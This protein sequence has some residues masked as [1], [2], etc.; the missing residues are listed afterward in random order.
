MA[1]NKDLRG[2]NKFPWWGWV[3]LLFVLVFW[4]LNW[5][6]EGLRTHIG[7]FPLWL[8][9]CLSIDALTYMRKG[10]SLISRNLLAYFSLFIVSAPAWWLFEL[11]NEKAQYWH[12]THR[13]EFT[14][15][16]YFLYASMSFSTVI[17]A[18]FGTSEWMGSFRWIQNMASGPRIGNSRS[19]R[20]IMLTLGLLMFA[21]LFIYPQYSAAFI[22]MSLYLIL[23]PLNNILGHRTLIQHTGRG[24]W[25]EV[26]ALWVASLI[27]GFFWELW[28]IYSSPKW[29]YTVPYVDFW[30]VFEMPLL[31][32]L[33]YLPFALEL[34]ALYHLLIGF[35]AK[36]KWQSYLQILPEVQQN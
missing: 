22:W 17:P 11:L 7:F 36:S 1:Q 23:D 12:Y 5:H 16:A 2:K 3:G 27:C 31:G 34:F 20:L 10:N 24:D 13:E 19:S 15:V 25:K 21:C 33:G 8:G 32:Y 6:L 14:D 28:N 30:H 35:F 18:I 4:Y 26:I 9:Y 29:Y